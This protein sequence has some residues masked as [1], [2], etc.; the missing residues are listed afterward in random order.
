MDAF[1]HNIGHG[2]RM[3][4]SASRNNAAKKI[5]QKLR[6]PIKGIYLMARQQARQPEHP[7]SSVQIK[8]QTLTVPP[9]TKK[10]WKH[11]S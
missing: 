7:A 9:P 1:T 2:P 11:E 8:P 3:C 6:G 10:N 5:C 4:L